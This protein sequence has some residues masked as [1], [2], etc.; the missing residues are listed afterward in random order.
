MALSENWRVSKTGYLVHKDANYAFNK[1]IFSYDY[2][3]INTR[4]DYSHEN[5]IIVPR[6]QRKFVKGH[7]LDEI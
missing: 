2:A 7:N 4:A 3:R 5:C 6:A 1:G